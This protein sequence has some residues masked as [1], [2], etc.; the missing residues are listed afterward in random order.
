MVQWISA[1]CW[2]L[3]NSKEGT[4]RISGH[5]SYPNY[6]YTHKTQSAT[7]N[8]CVLSRWNPDVRLELKDALKQEKTRNSELQQSANQ[9]SPALKEERMT[10]Q[11]QWAEPKEAFAQSDWNSGG[12][13][14]VCSCPTANSVQ[15]LVASGAT[16]GKVKVLVWTHP[17]HW[18]QTPPPNCTGWD[19]KGSTPPAAGIRW[20]VEEAQWH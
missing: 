12:K 3:S 13:A 8:A 17:Q 9:T 1:I 2:F 7:E 14:E 20:F 4:L 15:L 6:I 16:A 10:W 5:H 18:F 19:H 11:R